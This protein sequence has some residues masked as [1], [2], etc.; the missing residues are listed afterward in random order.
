MFGRA[1]HVVA[2]C[3]MA[4][5]SEGLISAAR[6]QSAVDYSPFFILPDLPDVVVLDGAIGI[7]APLALRRVLNGHPGV[8]TVILNSDGGNVQA[9]LLIAEE[10]FDRRMSTV[11]LPESRCMSACAYIFFA[12]SRRLAKGELGVHQISG[13]ESVEAAQYGLSDVL[14]ILAKYGVSQK[15]ITQMLRTPPSEMY[16]FSEQEV[17]SW[18][19]NS[20]D[21]ASPPVAREQVP[22]PAAPGQGSGDFAKA[23]VLG[24]IVS[25][26]LPPDQLAG[27]TRQAYSDVVMFYGK[28]MSKA[29]VIEEKRKYST[30]WPSRIAVVRPATTDVSCERDLCRVSGI[31]DWAVSDPKRKKSLKGS[32]SF[33]YLVRMMAGGSYFIVGED[34]KVLE[35]SAG[36]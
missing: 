34:G 1:A 5:L 20:A 16:V 4:F 12:G 15:V 25:G 9:G 3:L 7:S 21:F 33:E 14:E 31:Y 17:Q 22:S 23:F 2:L 32:A 10:V 26:S 18:G 13:I 24:L 29:E 30:R 8:N 28:S 11:I 19:I 6:A 35:R 36:R 27:V